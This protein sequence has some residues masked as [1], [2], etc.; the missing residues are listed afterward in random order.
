MKNIINIRPVLTYSPLWNEWFTSVELDSLSLKGLWRTSHSVNAQLR[1]SPK[2]LKKMGG[3]DML[4]H[5]QQ[6]NH[7]NI[8]ALPEAALIHLCVLREECI[9]M[10]LKDKMPLDLDMIEFRRVKYDYLIKD[11]HYAYCSFLAYL[12][13]QKKN[14]AKRSVKNFIEAMLSE[15]NSLNGAQS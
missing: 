13:N 11:N 12:K 6:P 10:F 15:F 2:A 5:K 14:H 4:T 7:Y 3:Y 1:E 8:R 9:S